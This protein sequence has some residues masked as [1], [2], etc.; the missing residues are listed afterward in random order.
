MCNAMIKKN[1]LNDTLRSRRQMFPK[2]NDALSHLEPLFILTSYHTGKYHKNLAVEIIKEKKVTGPIVNDKSAINQRAIQETFNIFLKIILVKLKT[3]H[4]LDSYVEIRKNNIPKEEMEKCM[5]M[6]NDFKKAKQELSEHIDNLMTKVEAFEEVLEKCDKLAS[7]ELL[8]QSEDGSVS[9]NGGANSCRSSLEFADKNELDD[10]ENTNAKHAETEDPIHE[11][12]SSKYTFITNFGLHII[13]FENPM[14]EMSD[15][16]RQIKNVDENPLLDICIFKSRDIITLENLLKY[17]DLSFHYYRLERSLEDV[18]RGGLSKK[19]HEKNLHAIYHKILKLSIRFKR[20]KVIRRSIT[21][22]EILVAHKIYNALNAARTLLKIL[23]EI[24]LKELY[25]HHKYRFYIKL[26]LSSLSKEVDITSHIYHVLFEIHV[27]LE[28]K[29]QAIIPKIRSFLIESER[30]VESYFYGNVKNFER[31]RSLA[32][33]H[34]RSCILEYKKIISDMKDNF[35]EKENEKLNSICFVVAEIAKENE[36]VLEFLKRLEEIL[37]ISLTKSFRIFYSK[38]ATDEYYVFPFV[39]YV[40]VIAM[41][42]KMIKNETNVEK[43][44]DIQPNV[45]EDEMH[46]LNDVSFNTFRFLY[47]YVSSYIEKKNN[48]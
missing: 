1:S 39:C 40:N 36:V 32:L 12:D 9:D 44:Y 30:C 20:E 31:H 48:R 13:K 41:C 15:K 14:T 45:C 10:T 46:F 23:G 17:F 7:F 33:H 35:K 6:K 25:I 27:L 2:H 22:D 42:S 11:K 3:V 19:H 8:M 47:Y 29:Q 28:E 38:Q 16:S 24:F 34:L 26:N 43:C 4:K 37:T 18:R 21:I 5:S